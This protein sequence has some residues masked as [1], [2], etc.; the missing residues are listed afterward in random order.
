MN[1]YCICVLKVYQIQ[2]NDDSTLETCYVDSIKIHKSKEVVF[3]K[4]QRA[5]LVHDAVNQF[6][7][8]SLS[9]DLIQTP[10]ELTYNMIVYHYQKPCDTMRGTLLALVAQKLSKFTK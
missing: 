10:K 5:H 4:L 1:L 9:A 6:C 2:Y 7:V 8:N 3:V